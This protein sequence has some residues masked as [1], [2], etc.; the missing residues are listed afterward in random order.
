[1]ELSGLIRNNM[2]AS[3]QMA[4]IRAFFFLVPIVTAWWYEMHTRFELCVDL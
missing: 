1:M 4:F 2:F 3:C